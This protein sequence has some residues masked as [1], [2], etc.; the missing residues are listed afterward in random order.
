MTTRRAPLRCALEDY[1]TVR[2][3]LGFKLD[4]AGRLL[5]QFV[6]YLEAHG[7]DPVTIDH[8]LAWATLPAEASTR[9]PTRT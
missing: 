5:G 7:V 3:A 9:H 4:N 1:L 6:G 2:R 8:A